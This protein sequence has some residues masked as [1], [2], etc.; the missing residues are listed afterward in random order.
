MGQHLGVLPRSSVVPVAFH[1]SLATGAAS[2]FSATLETADFDIYK[3]Y[4][5]TQR[6]S[7][8]GYTLDE[9]IDAVTGLSMLSVDMS[10][11][12]DAGYWITDGG[13]CRAALSPD[14]TLDGVTVAA[15]LDSWLLETHSSYS[16]R[17]YMEKKYPS[18]TGPV[19][20]TTTNNTT[21][22]INLTE[23]IDAQTVVTV[24]TKLE[25]WDAT[26]GSWHT[27]IVTAFSYPQATVV[28]ASDGSSAMAATVA[29]ADM[30]WV[31]D[32][33]NVNVVRFGNA[34]NSA[35]SATRGTAG[36]A[37]PAAAAAAAGGLPVSTAGS[38]DLDAKIGALTFTVANVLDANTRRIAGVVVIGAGTS[39]DKWRA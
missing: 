25:W 12:S 38:L 34:A 22:S 30:V 9:A 32:N 33:V 21:T 24:G 7:S 37:L 19:I 35:W 31:T 8:N 15:W 16:T 14:E 39:G 23:I 11:N 17:L 28:N 26:D 27:A 18:A 3:G 5:E 29:A 1:T 36:T 4:T 20:T 13:L 2:A 6:S 10:D